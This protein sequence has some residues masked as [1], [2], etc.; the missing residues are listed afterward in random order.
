MIGPEHFHI[1]MVG[2]SLLETE[3]ATFISLEFFTSSPEKELGGGGRE[4]PT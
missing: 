4:R 1:H 2:S 3:M